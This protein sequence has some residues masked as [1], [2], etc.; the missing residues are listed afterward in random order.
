MRQDLWCGTLK[1]ILGLYHVNESESL[2]RKFGCEWTYSWQGVVKKG[3]QRRCVVCAGQVSS[4]DVRWDLC[5][6][7]DQ[8]AVRI[9]SCT[10]SNSIEYESPEQQGGLAPGTRRSRGLRLAICHTI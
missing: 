5:Q 7:P 3:V 8:D 4:V 1:S 10:E 2:C 9:L 6:D